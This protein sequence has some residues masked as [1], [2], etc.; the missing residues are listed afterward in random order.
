MGVVDDNNTLYVFNWGRANMNCLN[1]Q[2][3]RQYGDNNCHYTEIIIITIIIN[4]C[5]IIIT[6]KIIIINL[7]IITLEWQQD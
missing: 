6:I 4:I 1:D 5:I 7:T 2:P 3:L